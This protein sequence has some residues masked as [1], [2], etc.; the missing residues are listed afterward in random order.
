MSEAL[1][2]ILIVIVMACIA[3]TVNG[4]ARL[5]ASRTEYY[6]LAIWAGILAMVI[7][8]IVMLVKSSLDYRYILGYIVMLIILIHTFPVCKREHRVYTM[9]N[10]IRKRMKSYVDFVEPKNIDNVKQRLEAA[11]SHENDSEFI[12][13]LE[14]AAK[15][16]RAAGNVDEA[17][18]VERILK[19]ESPRLYALVADMLITK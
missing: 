15:D 10:S 1:S 19:S 11:A 8:I 3:F 5:L 6:A 4:I 12:A 7:G 16:M 2:C 18:V 13:S 14:Q 17:E 9:Q